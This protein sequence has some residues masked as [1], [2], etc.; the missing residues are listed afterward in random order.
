MAALV[1]MGPKR[2]LKPS[3]ILRRRFIYDGLMGGNRKWLILGGVAWFFFLSRRVLVGGPPHPV[4]AE[5]LAP[6]E[7]LLITHIPGSGKR[8]R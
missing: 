3:F 6:G 7:K 4:Y 1:G 8:R 2:R 5:D